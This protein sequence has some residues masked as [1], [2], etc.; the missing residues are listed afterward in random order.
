MEGL[1]VFTVWH[2]LQ[3]TGYFAV[4]WDGNVVALKLA[5]WQLAQSVEIPA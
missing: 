1:H 4:T 3:S 2:N 5:V